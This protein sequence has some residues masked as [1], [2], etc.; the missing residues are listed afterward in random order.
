MTECAVEVYVW[1]LKLA[2]IVFYFIADT[3]AL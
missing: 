1:F 3:F 2:N